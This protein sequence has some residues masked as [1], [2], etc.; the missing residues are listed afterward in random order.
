MKRNI[1][2][3]VTGLIPH[4]ITQAMWSFVDRGIVINK[5]VIITTQKGKKI[6]THGDSKKNIDSFLQEVKNDNF[7]NES[8]I[9]ELK[10]SII[11]VLTIN[12]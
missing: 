8:K 3:A 4:F 1:L 6:L 5:I 11:Q 12:N 2:L 10:D 9:K 7:S